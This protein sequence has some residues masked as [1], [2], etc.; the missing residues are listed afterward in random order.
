MDI[1]IVYLLDTFN[2]HI[3]G[4][5]LH[6]AEVGSSSLSSPTKIIPRRQKVFVVGGLFLFKAKIRLKISKFKW[7]V[8]DRV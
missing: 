3:R 5:C 2:L 7:T 6:T 4:H 1:L 8:M